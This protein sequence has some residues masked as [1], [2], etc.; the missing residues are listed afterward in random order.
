MKVILMSATAETN[1]FA[2]YFRGYGFEGRGGV[3]PPI[4]SVPGRLYPVQEYYLED[5]V[6][7]V[8]R[9]MRVR[10]SD[11]TAMFLRHELGSSL[12]PPNSVRGE[13][14]PYDLFEA[15]IAHITL[16][17]PDGAIL[18]F[19][20]GWQEINMLQTKL[21]EDDVFRVGFGDPNRCRVYPLHSSVPTA[22]QQ[23][24]FERPPSGIRKIILS[25][26]IAET[27]VTVCH[28]F[29]MAFFFFFR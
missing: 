18:V 12:P 2:E 9:D 24:V 10:V 4:V 21:K 25:T 16:T 6:D 22:G 23:E 3:Y 8:E 5:V 14:F 29:E 15:L 11:D 28:E 27:S 13:E 17:K 26:N 20:P 1:L 19:L 7:I